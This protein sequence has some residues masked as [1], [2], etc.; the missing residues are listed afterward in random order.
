MNI[1]DYFV[2]AIVTMLR[3]SAE[4]VEAGLKLLREQQG[5]EVTAP[6][7]PRRRSLAVRVQ[8]EL[9]PFD[10]WIR[11]N[12]DAR[13]HLMAIAT[14]ARPDLPSHMAAAFAGA[15]SQVV[16]TRGR[17]YTLSLTRS[18]STKL[19]S[20][21]LI[22]LMSAQAE[23]RRA[24]EAVAAALTDSNQLNGGPAVSA[25]ALEAYLSTPE[26]EQALDFLAN[27][28]IRELQLVARDGGAALVIP[29]ALEDRFLERSS[30]ADVFGGLPLDEQLE[31]TGDVSAADLTLLFD[32]QA[33]RD[34]VWGAVREKLGELGHGAEL[35]ALDAATLTFEHR[36]YLGEMQRACRDAGRDVVRPS[37]LADR[38]GTFV[39]HMAPEDRARYLPESERLV[40]APNDDGWECWVLVDCGPAAT[41]V[42]APPLS[43]ALGRLAD[44]LS[45]IETFAKRIASP[46]AEA[47]ELAGRV[48]RDDTAELTERQR[49]V[50]GAKRALFADF[51][52][53]GMP[54]ETIR[55]LL[56]ADVA[57]VFGGMGSWN[58]EVPPGDDGDAHQR[59]SARLFTALSEVRLAAF[60]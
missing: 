13:A 55:A 39:E 49:D 11:A 8:G 56:A 19:D 47:F 58:D 3:G 26:G 25:G 1:D 5:V 33:C 42:P 4:N 57:S 6:Q 7:A 43:V 10:A 12:R 52:A 22:A 35:A 36:V 29:A 54:A 48:L 45:A 59:L 50:L 60:A 44:D 21:D 37:A 17:A 23:P 53:L 16:A 24:R 34:A 15:T 32:A 51:A 9:R 14:F 18:R 20:R 27:D 40:L 30:V 31:L 2:M 38:L 41:A 46:F 28:F